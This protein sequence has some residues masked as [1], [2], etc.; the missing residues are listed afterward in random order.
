MRQR[1]V[2]GNWKMHGRVPTARSLISDI[3]EGLPDLSGDLQIAVCPSFVHLDL[4][5][6]ILNNSE[7]FRLRSNG[8]YLMSDYSYSGELGSLRA[9]RK[10]LMIFKTYSVVKNSELFFWLCIRM[11]TMPNLFFKSGVSLLSNQLRA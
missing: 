9:S 5:S 11:F 4:V 7:N 8:I 3:I 10:S 2:I 6:Q 1:I